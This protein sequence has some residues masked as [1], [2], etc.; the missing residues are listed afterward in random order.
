MARKS[1]I[2]CF[3]PPRVLVLGIHKT[4]DTAARWGTDPGIL[5][6]KQYTN[7]SSLTT[8]GTAVEYTYIHITASLSR[9]CDGNLNRTNQ[10]LSESVVTSRS[11]GASC[12]GSYGRGGRAA[13]I[14][15]R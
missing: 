11:P 10:F 15:A 1:D 13:P 14:S 9:I 2:L 8:H 5:Y 4:N 12:A 3:F 7:E 6:E